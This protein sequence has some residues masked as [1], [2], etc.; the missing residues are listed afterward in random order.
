M[1][2]ELKVPRY[3][4]YLRVQVKSVKSLQVL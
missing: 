4:K 2:K 3:K 1:T